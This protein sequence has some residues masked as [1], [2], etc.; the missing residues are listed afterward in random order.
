MRMILNAE[1]VRRLIEHDPE[2]TV[3]MARTAAQQVANE[4]VN[5]VK[6]TVVEK[7]VEERINQLLHGEVRNTLLTS[8][9]RETISNEVAKRVKAVTEGAVE[10]EI[11]GEIRS[12]VK[13]IMEQH[14]NIMLAGL[15]DK[16]DALIRERFAAA[17]AIKS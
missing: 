5:R 11:F 16:I 1:G 13:P 6:K 14:E 17:F 10:R 15:S 8:K 9:A 3:E 2:G 12:L 7:H 4:I